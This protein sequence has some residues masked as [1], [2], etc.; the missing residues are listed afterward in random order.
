MIFP[1]DAVSTGLIAE[2][3]WH[4][5]HVEGKQKIEG[6]KE[7]GT[8][9]DFGLTISQPNIAH[10]HK[11]IVIESEGYR[12][13]LLV[14]TKLESL[15]EKY[16]DLTTKQELVLKGRMGFLSLLLYNIHGEALN[17]LQWILCKG[18]KLQD[19]KRW[20]EEG[21]FP[22]SNST[23]EIIEMLG[24]GSIG[25]DDESIIKNI[26]LAE[27]RNAFSIRIYWKDSD[28]KSSLNRLNENMQKPKEQRV[29]NYQILE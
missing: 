28:F 23:A 22:N 27:H 14:Q 11:E 1:S 15:S 4:P 21:V 25:T 6:E 7:T 16:G 29:H 20:L 13:G 19:A 3:S 26:I 2:V 9:G 10:K 5:R 8:G 12:S 24:K 17:N 18:Y